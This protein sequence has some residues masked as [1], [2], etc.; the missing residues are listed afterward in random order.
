MSAQKSAKLKYVPADINNL[1]WCPFCPWNKP[2]NYSNR[3]RFGLHIVNKHY[4]DVAYPRGVEP[5]PFD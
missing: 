1:L 5:E 2:D 3:R 4:E